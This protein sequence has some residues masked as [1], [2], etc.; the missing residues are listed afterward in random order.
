M[1][2]S[3]EYMIVVWT[4]LM[5]GFIVA[6]LVV[7]RLSMWF[8][9]CVLLISAT[10]LILWRVAVWGLLTVS[11]RE[12]GDYARHFGEVNRLP[13]EDA[14]N[15]A[16]RAL[17]DTS[18]FTCV[19][20][21]QKPPDAVSRLGGCTFEVF[22]R[23]RQIKVLG[24]ETVLGWDQIED[25]EYRKDLIRIGTDMEFTEYAVTPGADGIFVLD[26]PLQHVEDREEPLYPTIYHLIATIYEPW[27]RQ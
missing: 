4:S 26:S 18:V 5:G 2:V 24:Q 6:H 13:L 8:L 25:S 21:D 17:G 1:R 22:S 9:L 20:A 15:L 14:R 12:S 16:E 7:G 3:R 11:R 10:L 27:S 23:Y 19:D